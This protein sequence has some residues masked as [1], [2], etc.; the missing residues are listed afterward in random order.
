MRNRATTA[1]LL[2]ALW[3]LAA[4]AQGAFP[5]P[6]VRYPAFRNAWA[7]VTSSFGNG[8]PLLRTPWATGYR[9]VKIDARDGPQTGLGQ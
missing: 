1:A 9:P 5:A 2:L 8:T 7:I 4:G 3:P 6:P